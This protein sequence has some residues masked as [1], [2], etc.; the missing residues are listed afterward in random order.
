MKVLEMLR[1]GLGYVLMAM[2][3]SSSGALRKKPSGG[4]PAKNGTPRSP[5]KSA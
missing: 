1:R 2:G 3:A 5:Q 4:S